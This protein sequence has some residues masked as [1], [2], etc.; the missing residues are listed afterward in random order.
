MARESVAE[1]GAPGEFVPSV[2]G[3]VVL[4]ALFGATAFHDG[5]PFL[6]L[7]VV[8]GSAL[9]AL[10]GGIGRL[11]LGRSRGST[12]GAAGLGVGL[13]VAA[14][15]FVVVVALGRGGADFRIEGDV[16]IALVLS[17]LAGIAATGVGALALAHIRQAPAA[18]DGDT[19]DLPEED[20]ADYSS[21][22][23]ELVC[24]LTNQIVQPQRDR[25]MVCHNRMNVT[26]QCHAVYLMDYSHLLEG[27][28]RRCFQPLRDR[29][30]RGFGS[31]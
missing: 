27:R 4:A 10:A 12:A 14:M 22:P 28:C 16:A 17:T 21:R 6:P 7:L 24:L 31:P 26:Q 19:D 9:G 15:A 2:V 3:L 29:D 1:W 30:K 8:G 5:S 20:D 18:E 11:V 13:F 23:Q 25:F